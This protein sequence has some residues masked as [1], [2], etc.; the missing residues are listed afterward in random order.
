MKGAPRIRGKTCMLAILAAAAAHAA[1]SRSA[2][3]S[4]SAAPAGSASARPS[5]VADTPAPVPKATSGDAVAAPADGELPEPLEA[6]PS[7]GSAS[8]PRPTPP[9]ARAM[10]DVAY[11]ATPQGIVDAMLKLAE[12][13]ASDVVYDLG[14][15]D[16]RSLVTAAQRYGARGVG[17][18]LDPRLV[19]EARKNVRQAGVENLVRI[20]QAD[21]FTL[22]L[23]PADVI[24]LYL[25][26]RL[27]HKLLPQL[28]K[29]RPGARIVSHEYEIP[30]A[31][32]AK[33]IQVRG[34]KNG[35][36]DLEPEESVM[37]RIYLWKAPW[38]KQPTEWDSD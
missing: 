31:R 12:T 4:P 24:F 22:D 25:V 35:P 32:P 37:H 30:G 29:L 23:S 34:P 7:A 27:N 33:I 2:V 1:C 28:E 16:A 14:C 20:E 8:E 6:A 17:F 11:W 10:P 9:S 38:Q 15:G 21:I 18:D 26:P 5:S 19:E 36:P 3:S 13:K